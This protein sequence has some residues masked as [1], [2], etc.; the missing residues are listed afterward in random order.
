MAKKAEKRFRLVQ[1]E[2]GHSYVIPAD[3]MDDFELFATSDEGEQ[4][5]DEF[6]PMMMNWHPSKL[7]FTDPREGE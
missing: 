1:D 2:S 6:E 7:T 4:F 3:R 5:S